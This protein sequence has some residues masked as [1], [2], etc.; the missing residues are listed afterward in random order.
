MSKINLKGHGAM[1]LA[2]SSWGLMSP[3]AKIVMATGAVSPLILTDL[4]VAGAMLLFWITSFFMKPEHVG[5]RDHLKLLGASLLAIVFNQ[6][7]FI[8]GVSLSSPADA[9]II[10]TSIPLWATVL[11][12]FF[13][14]EPVTG[15]K[16]LGIAL[17][18][19]GAL[20]LV[21]GSGQTQASAD[22]G[23]NHIW[24]D[25][26]VLMAQLSYASYIVLFKNFVGRYSLVTIMKWM[27]TYAF[28]FTLPFSYR[29]LMATPWTALTAQ[30][31]W[32]ILFI[33][34]VATFVSYMLIVVG[35]KNLRPTVAGMYNYVQPIVACVVTV[36]LGM[37]TFNWVK[38]L[39]VGMIF[40]GVYLV[41][42]SRSR[43]EVENYERQHAQ[44]APDTSTEKAD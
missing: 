17:G 6:G 40:G 11:A 27:F 44:T 15:K 43:Q 26:L 4:R 3:V 36:C 42:A 37:D 33:V 23:A 10:T 12:A 8:F 28:I 19:A 18:A 38:G 5:H 25:L 14:K 21:L 32:A 2:N 41:T 7:C 16:V 20:L 39:A 1:L 35:Q 34:V 22:D 31:V 30:A 9:S 24:G 13:L 29:G